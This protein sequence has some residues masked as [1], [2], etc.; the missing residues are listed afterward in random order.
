MSNIF[1]KS[2]NLT[3]IFAILVF[4]PCRFQYN[5]FRWLERAER[6]VWTDRK[7][8]LV[9]FLANVMWNSILV[10]FESSE[11][12]FHYF[13]LFTNIFNN[14]VR[15]HWLERLDGLT[16]RLFWSFFDK[17]DVEF[18]FVFFFTNLRWIFTILVFLQTHFQ[19]VRSHWLERV[20][21]LDC[22]QDNF[23]LLFE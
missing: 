3:W 21:C 23:G 12:D 2:E 6:A 14:Y 19:Y 15:S 18:Y 13:G 22:Q 17:C 9:F 10:F 16:E 1:R 20:S 8:I 11:V 5:R 7:T 4:F